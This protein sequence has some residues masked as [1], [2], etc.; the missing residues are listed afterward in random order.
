MEQ[1]NPSQHDVLRITEAILPLVITG[2]SIVYLS[3][4]RYHTKY[5]TTPEIESIT[6]SLE[7]RRSALIFL[8]GFEA[9][10]W[11]YLFAQ[12]SLK[13][14]NH[15]FYDSMTLVAFLINWLSL[16]VL[17]F[18]SPNMNH[19]KD[20]AY[21][22][23]FTFMYCI[24]FLQSACRL[25]M[26]QD[27]VQYWDISYCFVTFVLFV[28]TGT[29]PQPYHPRDLQPA[30]YE[31]LEI[32]D[33]TIYLNDLILSPEATASVFS[34]AAFQWMNP[35]VV[36]GF[37]NP[38]TRKNIYAMTFQHLSRSAYADFVNTKNFINHTKVLRRIYS[39]NK[40][41]I[42]L[43]FVFATTACVIGYLAPFFQ[44]KLLEYF[45]HTENRTSGSHQM[46][47]LYVLGMFTV[48]VVKL[49]CNSVQ[50][51]VGRRWNVRTFIMLDSEIFSKTLRRK[52]M[53][54]KVSKVAEKETDET[55]NDED[56]EKDEHGSFSNVGKIT[57]LMSIDA[58][59]LS[60]IPAF[61]H[62][63]YAAPVEATVAMFY[64]YKLLGNAALVGLSV[65]IL[66]F[67]I[68]GYISKKM[69][70]SYQAYT[71][72]K[73]QRNELVNELLQ[74]IRMIKYFA[75]EAKWTEKISESRKKEV[76]KMIRVIII[77][78]LV[79]V[80]Y[81]TV[82]VLVTASTFI[83]YTKVSE[84]EL[85]ASIAFVSITLFEMLRAPLIFIP[86]TVNTFTEAYVNLKRI[87]DYLNEP[88]V[89]ENRNK[90]PIEVPEGV[91]PHVVL[92]R[93]GFEQSLFQW[94]L[95]K[96][97]ETA[98]KSGNE[99]QVV[100]SSPSA[101]TLQAQPVH[102]AFQLTVPQFNFPTGKL[103]VVC[104]PTGSGKSSF[105]HA[106]LGEMDIVT[107]RV[108]LPSKTILNVNN[109]SKIDPE[110]PSLYLDKVAYVAQQPFLQHA[111]IRD[112]ILF[113]LPFD[114]ERYKKTLVQCALVKDLAILPD[115][116]RTEIG[117]K[118]IS[119]SGGQKQRVSLARAVY[120][121][122]KT[123]L[124]DD[125][126]S[127]VDS[128]TSKHIYKQC[129]MGDLLKG[130]TVILV[131]HYV[132]LVLKGASFL[133]K[134]DNGN[135]LGCDSV[136]RLRASG[137][138]NK[139]LGD[140]DKENDEEEDDI[141]EIIDDD[142]TDIDFD[143]DGKKETA[144]LIQEET[145]EKGQ[146]KFKVYST[147]LSAC[148]G[149][150]F[151]ICLVIGY[152]SARLFTFA[153]N[154]WLRIWSAS[155]GTASHDIS[156]TA[157]MNETPQYLVMF[158]NSPPAQSVFNALGSAVQKQ[159]VFKSWVFEEKAPVNVDYYIGIYLILCFGFICADI[160]RNV[161][162]YYGTIRGACS[163][164][165]SMLS[166]II[167]APM[168][169]FDTTPLGRIL[170]RFGKDVSTID[171][172]I[173]RSAGFL[174][175]C[176]TGIVASTLVISAI[177]PQFLV[178]AVAVSCLYFLIGIFYLRISRELKRLN[179][180]SR[181]PIYSHFT[182][183]LVGVVT[184]RAYG[185]E[186][187]FMRTVYEKIDGYV[188]PF[189][190]LWMSNRWLYARIEFTGAFVTFFTGLFLIFNIDSIDAGMAGISLFYAGSF[191][192]HIYW[193]IRQYTAVEMDLNSV[194]RVQEYLEIDQEPPAQI[195]DHRPPAA[196]P[197]TAAIEVKDLV[198]RYAPELDP[199]LHGVSFATRPHEKIGIVGRTGSGKS[200]MA[201][202]FFRFLEAS[203]G[204][205]SIDGIDISKIGIQDLRS[206]ITIIP[207]D[208]VLFSGTIRSNIDPFDEH[209]D[210]AVW[211]SLE[212]AHIA[213]ASDRSKQVKS[214]TNS[215]ASTSRAPTINETE[216]QSAITSLYQQVSDGGN[217]FSQGQRQLL[218]LARALLRRS[219]LIIM[220]EATA[221]VDFDTDAKIQ[222]TI[223]EEFN[224]STL[225]CIAHRLRTVI[226]YDRILVLDQG[227]VVEYDTPHN[228]ITG[229]AGVG[230]FKSMCEKSG[231]LDVLLR[232]ASEAYN[233]KQDA[234]QAPDNHAQIY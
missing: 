8:T 105:L 57:N 69:N 49:L 45:E 4:K 149:W 84:K 142:S 23:V 212:R 47:Y 38:V 218:C 186:D 18:T 196:W 120:S 125:C 54:G 158:T 169:F 156:L 178:V 117:E 145:S 28:I 221:S 3:L 111:S 208:A 7:K 81:L 92:T 209:S 26:L 177:T 106:L 2:L 140:E 25:L 153:E 37:H 101:S 165:D 175:D 42:W 53:L 224:N 113:G 207:Q 166:R 174:I 197:T 160:I 56:K 67:P 137:E 99:E 138:L 96:E 102:R 215:P 179:S 41:E 167:H 31:K 85:T 76:S 203:S 108:Y 217:N 118:G 234:E 9:I 73:D 154:W 173:A 36:F 148:G 87:S 200:T 16:L 131:T 116:D 214:G 93:T 222:R 20:R 60:N 13:P 127:A 89:D 151:W 201:L 68:T 107:G 32:K 232:M 62:M 205:I 5:P 219:K 198:I 66:C 213:K 91:Q 202:S 19:Y 104:G 161:L 6:V 35:L 114:A 163:L 75:W 223:R 146:V 124:L 78:V 133:V 228:L 230:V 195:K 52:D 190:L 27:N 10:G 90:E 152:V 11:L 51:W 227:E 229:N 94:H 181:S 143:L 159:N 121:H 135:V 141:E 191:L 130:R 115:G 34:W 58:D 17:S 79:H 30:S 188:A 157:M 162:V 33:G 216:Q 119:L 110:Y 170:N 1:H 128:H 64:L 171:M 126:L 74:G 132:R 14:A 226:D 72:A 83:W 61:I 103:S 136:E 183:S 233:N 95:E 176:V 150:F 187:Q 184:I 88:E 199:V 206:Q 50:L 55:K 231:E 204:S 43:Q 194:E 123:V 122:A 65:M 86:E 71:T 193:F 15:D 70:L 155:Y 139:L 180:V 189:Y 100:S 29:T 59:H 98:D 220:D 182:E 144:K 80:V 109:V 12:Y 112:N 48:G 46:A 211:E 134:I 24:L 39:S 164:F 44:Q 129:L 225:L 21:N 82:P 168:R 63:I 40:Q 77:D 97:K 22:Y 210:E 185:V 147:Y 172:Q 192:E